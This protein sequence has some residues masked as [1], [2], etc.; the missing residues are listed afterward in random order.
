MAIEKNGTPNG[1]I[2]ERHKL[3]CATGDTNHNKYW[4]VTLYDSDDV[5]VNFGRVGKTSQQGVHRCVG[6]AFMLK[7]M[8]E[9]QKGKK[10]KKTQQYEPYTEIK[11]ID[12]DVGA[13]ISPSAGKDLG[14]ASLKAIAKDQIQHSS[15]ATAKLIDWLTDVNRHAISDATGGQVTWN[16]AKG[17][18]ATPLGIILP[19]AVSE[20]RTLLIAIADEVAKGDWSKRKFKTNVERFMTIV[21]QNVG[22]RWTFESVFP[23]VQAVQKQNAILDALDASYLAATA[24]PTKGKAKTA[25]APKVFETK[26]ELISNKRVTDRIKD[27]FRATA[28]R[29]HYDA[30]RMKLVQAWS[31]DIEQM[32]KA[33]KTV[34]KKLNNVNEYWHGTNATN[35]LSILKV[36]LVIPPASSPHCTGRMWGDGLYFAPSSTKSLNYATGFWG[37]KGTQRIFMFLAD[38]AMGKAFVPVRGG[39]WNASYPVRG[40]DSVHAVGGKSGVQNDECIV[41]QTNQANLTYL[42]EFKY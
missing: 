4:T 2:V 25:K 1:N 30:N 6:K 7:K 13:N 12:S 39:A 11:A 19:N 28:N 42:C 26:L 24:T 18:F 14:K 21:P 8:K 29:N 17:M 5:H 31:V 15:P 41:Y 27:K 37:Q 40:H 36:G 38:V 35:V 20:A 16:A 3:M 33:F 32:T 34:G 23:N 9:K 22:M 10:N